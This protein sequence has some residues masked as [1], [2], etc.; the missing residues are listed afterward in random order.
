[1]EVLF[2]LSPRFPK[3]RERLMLPAIAEAG[4]EEVRAN[5]SAATS[6]TEILYLFDIVND[7]SYLSS[8]SWDFL[9]ERGIVMD[10]AFR[11]RGL[12]KL[13]RLVGLSTVLSL[14]I[15]VALTSGICS[16]S[17]LKPRDKN[18]LTVAIPAG[19]I[20]LDPRVSTDA[21][22]EKINHLICDGLMK[23]DDSM[24]VVPN[25]AERFEQISEIS[26][27][28]FLRSGVKFHDG[29]PLTA[30]DVVYTYRSI[31]D[32]EVVS[33]H[34]SAFERIKAVVAESPLVV[35]ID[36]KEV[37]APFMT[38]LKRGIVSKA[39]AKKLGDGYGMAP[40][41][42]G[43]Y[44]LVK[45]TPDQVVILEA[46]KDYYGQVPKTPGLRFEVIK[47]D[48]VRVLKL[49]K[50]DIDL[51]Q[52]DIPPL[53]IDRLLKDEKLRRVE[54]TG[55]VVTYMGMNMT[56]DILK[57][58]KVRQAIAYAMD[59]DEIISHRWRGLAVK[60]NS[61]LAPGNW[62]YDSKL[63]QY[64]YDPKKAAALLD[65][66]GYPVPKTGSKN[67]FTITLKTSTVKSRIDIARMI[68]KQLARVGIDV[69]VE[70]YEWGTF[71]KDVK[72]G[73]FQTYTLSWVGVTEPDI[74]YDVCGSKQI[75]PNGLNRGRFSDPRVDKLVAEGRLTLDEAKRK[76]IYAEVQAIL[77]KK[78]PYIPLWYEKNIA[79]FQKNL[80][81]VH[82]R[83]DA[84]YRPFVYIEKK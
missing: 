60:A 56:D 31:I 6:D 62:A 23:L 50:G 24:N 4:M 27:R 14:S 64:S 75:P 69:K 15:S 16:C 83:M 18:V 48:N 40:I 20:T 78:L 44:K 17:G 32:G 55:I 28:F 2:A 10:K 35:R 34:R 54:D 66:A 65:E 77:I 52:N 30:D 81:G 8:N 53:L 71:Y 3:T 9:S 38:M 70:P 46:N 1:M 74:F 49:L 47:D 67:R 19:P 29:T 72:S 58:E 61:I 26:Y 59:R 63:P 42:T 5:T 43:P 13:L 82:L 73:N 79:I 39:T 76:K 41:G 12:E 37:Y 68:A 84:S 22:G 11:S 33:A 25:L 7:Y 80:S 36:F 51:V 57:K 21:V 45:F